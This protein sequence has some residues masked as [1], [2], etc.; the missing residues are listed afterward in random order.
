MQK[1][2]KI[3]KRVEFLEEKYGIK[4]AKTDGKLYNTLKFFYFISLIYILA[5]NQ[6]YIVSMIFV[7]SENEN[8]II[9]KNS[10][11]TVSICSLLLAAGC[12]FKCTRFKIVGGILTILPLPLL[13][14]TFAVKMQ[15]GLGYFGFKA[16]FY[17]RHAIPIVILFI[18]SSFMLI[19]ALRST[20]KFNKE[21]K[22][23]YDNIYDMYRSQIGYDDM[24][25]EQTDWEEF[26]KTYDPRDTKQN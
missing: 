17:W 19:I 1:Y 2:E 7:G 3:V 15:D 24:S 4:Y 9:D 14:F 6:L 13:F 22:K 5:I 11:I 23:A 16:S 26:L 25:V 18:L 10:I 8:Y 20:I 21:Y 12:V